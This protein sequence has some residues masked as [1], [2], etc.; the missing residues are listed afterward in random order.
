[1]DEAKKYERIERYLAGE[2]PPPERQ[3][4]ETLLAEDPQLREEV[5]LHRELAE[6]ARESDVAEFESALDDAMRN[7]RGISSRRRWLL[8]LLATLL[9]FFLLWLAGRL[10][11]ER[12]AAPA[13]TQIYA[14]YVNLPDELPENI[15]LRS[16]QAAP[17]SIEAPLRQ[18]WSAV[19]EAYRKGNYEQALTLLENLP[20]LDPDFVEEN[21]GTYH[22]YRGLLQ[23]RLKR[24]AA[25]A[26]S[27]T[28]VQSGNYAEDAAWKRAMALLLVEERQ[29]E[30][31]EILRRI[32]NTLHPRREEALE[33]LEKLKR[34]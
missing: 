20:S 5:V 17:P 32:G 18:N 34:Q 26:D 3:A 23:L 33:V 21:P 8:I 15:L 14:D 11:N 4:F 29:E 27:F 19:N 30:A 10:L 7:G 9:L 2:L 16:G 25:A 31:R 6:A 1:M 13:A 22:Y 28:R 12:S 24:P